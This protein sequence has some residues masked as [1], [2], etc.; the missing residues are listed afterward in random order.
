MAENKT[1][2]YYF[3][4]DQLGI[5]E[6]GIHLLRNRFNY[7]TIEYSSIQEIRIEKGKQIKNWLLVLLLGIF[8]VSTWD[9]YGNQSR[10]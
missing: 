1:N 3:E 5:S 9:V 6:T 8:S 10:L 7:E 2:K 4:T